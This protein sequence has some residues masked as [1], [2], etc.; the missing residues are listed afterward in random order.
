MEFKHKTAKIRSNSLIKLNLKEA[1]NANTIMLIQ[2]YYN[3]ANT[4]MLIQ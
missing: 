3:N 2:C 1:M 4:I